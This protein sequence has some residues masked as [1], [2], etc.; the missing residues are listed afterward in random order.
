MEKVNGE[1]VKDILKAN[2]D[3]GFSYFLVRF[4]IL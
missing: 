3:L 4:F 1:S 2:S